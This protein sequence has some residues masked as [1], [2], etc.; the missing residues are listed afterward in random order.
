MN[1]TTQI[2]SVF[3]EGPHDVAFIYRMLKSLGYKSYESC[4]I[5]NLPP[6]FDQLI[7]NEVEKSDIEK[8]NII[9]VRRGFLPTRIMQKKDKYVFLYSLGGDGKKTVRG[10]MLNDLV[11]FIP[12]EGEIAI[13]P[14]GT[15]LS[16]IY[17]FDADEKG[18][19]FRLN[20][21]TK[22]INE[23]LGTRGNVNFKKN[24]EIQSTYQINFGAYIFTG[25]DNNTGSLEDIL[26]PLM[27][28]NNEAIFDAARGYIGSYRKDAR[29]FPLKIKIK[30]DVVKEK[31]STKTKDKYK[32]Y[33][34]K[35]LIGT[36]GQLQCSGEANTVCITDSDYLTIEKMRADSK[37]NQILEFLNNI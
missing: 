11:S 31:R 10:K 35:S 22:E 4:K 18:V 27:Y 7:I 2:L 20:L 5:G 21:L 28:K 9:E 19:Q 17:L 8:L 37:S 29:L 23:V 15:T 6:P 12:E 1:A 13:L 14:N 3:C 25:K 34:S 24:G 16:V 36:V 26:I 30:E 33:F 32:F